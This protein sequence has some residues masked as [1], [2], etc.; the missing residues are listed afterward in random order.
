M[1]R[2]EIRRD[3]RYDRMPYMREIEKEL[4]ME[5]RKPRQVKRHLAETSWDL[6]K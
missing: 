1:R 4:D 6:V 2:P 5:R 3:L